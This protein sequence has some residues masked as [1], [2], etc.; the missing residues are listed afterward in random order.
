[1]NFFPAFGVVREHFVHRRIGNDTDYRTDL[2]ERPTRV[3]RHS[4]VDVDSELHVSAV[5]IGHAALAWRGRAIRNHNAFDAEFAGNIDHGA[6]D[7]LSSALTSSA[8][9]SAKHPAAVHA[10]TATTEARKGPNLTA[11]IE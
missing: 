4:Q 11:M 7:A 2:P 1:M 10:A 6:Q 8:D 5:R 3:M 9:G